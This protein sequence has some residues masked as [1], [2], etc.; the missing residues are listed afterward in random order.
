MTI[1]E[2]ITLRREELDLRQFQVAEAIGVTKATMCKYERNV[3]IPNAEILTKLA[4][5]LNTS[6]DYLC[7]LTDDPTPHGESR[8]RLRDDDIAVFKALSDLSHDNKMRLSGCARMMCWKN[9]KRPQISS[10]VLII[11]YYDTISVCCQQTLI[12]W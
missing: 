2:R 1:G 8:V 3:N 10:T 7:G 5:A 4:E 6:A 9:K 11:P 12:P